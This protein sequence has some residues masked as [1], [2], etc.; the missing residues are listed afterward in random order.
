M[1]FL[2]ALESIIAIAVT[3]DNWTLILKWV[4]QV[5]ASSAWVSL[6]IW[7]LLVPAFI[8]S[9]SERQISFLSRS[10][11]YPAA[12]ANVLCNAAQSIAPNLAGR[13][14]AS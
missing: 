4:A 11:P 12:H 14:P 8:T 10:G 5:V 9:I 1:K 13:I 7:G 2:V 3:F 6:K